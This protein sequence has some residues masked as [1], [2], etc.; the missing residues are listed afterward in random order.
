MAGESTQTRSH[1]LLPEAPRGV[2]GERIA[3]ALI[4]IPCERTELASRYVGE[5]I[6]VRLGGSTWIYPA[7]VV[8]TLPH[9]RRIL[10]SLADEVVR[11]HPIHLL[12]RNE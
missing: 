4:D 8:A 5:D 12:G 6:Q 9:V 3:V 11:I 2:T 7:V 1:L 10:V